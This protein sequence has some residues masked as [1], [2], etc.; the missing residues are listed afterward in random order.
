MACF[1]F[2]CRII[3]VA[4][5]KLPSQHSYVW[6]RLWGSFCISYK[7][8]FQFNS[9][10]ITLFTF[11][12]YSCSFFF[13]SNQYLLFPLFSRKCEILCR[14]SVRLYQTTVLVGPWPL[15]FGPKLIIWRV[16]RVTQWHSHWHTALL[17]PSCF[18][19]SFFSRS[20]KWWLSS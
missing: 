10:F 15:F 6:N 13:S 4:D 1:S 2:P 17:S 7:L 8:W 20:V 19:W 9:T 5:G 12:M 3:T 14:I 16:P 11:Q 18:S